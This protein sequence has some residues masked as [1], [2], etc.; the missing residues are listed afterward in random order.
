VGW[1]HAGAIYLVAIFV[2]KRMTLEDYSLGE[3]L[4]RLGVIQEYDS[5]VRDNHPRNLVGLTLMGEIVGGVDIKYPVDLD[6]AKHIFILDFLLRQ[7]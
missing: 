3:Q 2:I 1:R 4:R 5:S 7:P 6:I